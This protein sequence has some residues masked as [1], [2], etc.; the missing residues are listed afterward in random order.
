MILHLEN[1]ETANVKKISIINL[2]ANQ[3]HL[4]QDTSFQKLYI[5]EDIPT[6]GNSAGS[7]PLT[8]SLLPLGLY[9]LNSF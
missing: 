5:N 3:F 7:L 8:L 2:I 1:N 4:I 9:I 6:S